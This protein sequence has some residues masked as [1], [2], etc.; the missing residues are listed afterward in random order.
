MNCRATNEY[1]GI[2]KKWYKE[3]YT[4]VEREIYNV[5]YVR[6]IVPTVWKFQYKYN[7]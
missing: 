1:C 2:K 7:L 6:Y 4:V 3:I 5:L